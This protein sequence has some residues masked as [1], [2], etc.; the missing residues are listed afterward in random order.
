MRDWESIICYEDRSKL[1]TSRW[2]LAGVSTRQTAENTAAGVLWLAMSR[3]GD[4]VTANLY[5]D[6]ARGAGDLVAV[7]TADVSAIDGTAEAAAK[8]VFSEANTSGL[9]GSLYIHQYTADDACPLQ[10][11]L[12]TD[13]DLNALCDAIEDL[14]GYS[15]TLGMAEFIRLAGEDVLGK[16]A[17]MY[18]RQLGGSGAGE[19]WFIAGAS[20]NYPDLRRIANPA[21]LR[22]AC[23][24]R[25]LE[26]ALGRS[27]LNGED[28]AYS[29]LRDNFA[30]QYA[31][32]M[33]DLTLALTQGG[34]DATTVAQTSTRRLARA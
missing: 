14:P 11:A 25:A 2:L 9:S 34:P 4:S 26:V 24:Y 1:I 13:E 7:G 29:T 19:A 8:L 20:R 21:Q 33:N 28:T 23:A 31:T 30:S 5:K 12:C 17:R 22:L 6:E 32:V 15:A 16:V 18:R 27:H 3:V 10:V